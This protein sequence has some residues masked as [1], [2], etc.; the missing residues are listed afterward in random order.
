ML[1]WQSIPEIYSKNYK[2]ETYDLCSFSSVDCVQEKY[3]EFYVF[4]SLPTS[5]RV[6]KEFFF[7]CSKTPIAERWRAAL[8]I[9]VIFYIFKML[10][11]FRDNGENC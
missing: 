7:K 8:V 4:E 1:V 9:E 5:I 3:D 10:V 6:C 2:R 11:N